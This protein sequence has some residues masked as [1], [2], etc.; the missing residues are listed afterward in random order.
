MTIRAAGNRRLG[1]MTDIERVR[2]V[3]QSARRKGTED[4]SAEI[5]ISAESVHIILHKDLN[6]ILSTFGLKMLTPEHKETQT[7][8]AVDL[9]T[10]ANHDVDVL[11]NTITL[12]ET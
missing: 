8:V 3:V 9:I 12:S 4:I 10:T 7:T 2:N 1:P 6:N 5:R 11:N